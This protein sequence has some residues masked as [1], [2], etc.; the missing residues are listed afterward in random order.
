VAD[1]NEDVVDRVDGYEMDE[2]NVDEDVDRVDEMMEGVEDELGKLPRVFDFLTEASQK[3]LYPGCTKFTKLTAVLT[4][5]NSKSK[6]NM[7]DSSFTMLLEAL[8]EMLLREM[9]FQSRH[10]MPKS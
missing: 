3:P 10:T 8:G 2:E 9:N 6:L 4:I 7:S 5:F 1:V